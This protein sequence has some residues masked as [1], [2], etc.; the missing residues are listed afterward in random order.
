[1]MFGRCV[2]KRAI[3][4]ALSTASLP[5]FVKKNLV[6]LLGTTRCKLVMLL[7]K[8]AWYGAQF[9]CANRCRSACWLMADATAGWLCPV[10][11]T[12]IPHARSKYCFPVWSVMKLPAALS[13]TRF[14]T[15][16]YAGLQNFLKACWLK[17]RTARA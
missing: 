10:D 11:V 13:A 3:L 9:C 16:R 7:T 15:A 8:A 2:A 4:T 14:C 6:R 17:Q 1:M 12:P 5:E